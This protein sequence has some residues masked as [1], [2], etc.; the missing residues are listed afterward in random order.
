[1]PDNFVHCEVAF[2]G[3]NSIFAPDI[4]LCLMLIF[5]PVSQL[6]FFLIGFS[7]KLGKVNILNFARKKKEKKKEAN[8]SS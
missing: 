5:R 6:I 4:I 7:L 8:T 2:V 3:R 1:M